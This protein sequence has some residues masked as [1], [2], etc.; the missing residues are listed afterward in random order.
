[1]TTLPANVSGLEPHALIS[2]P[3]CSDAIA[4]TYTADLEPCQAS[5]HARAQTRKPRFAMEH[6]YTSQPSTD[7]IR[8][9]GFVCLKH[10]HDGSMSCEAHPCESSDFSL[11]SAS[12]G[13]CSVTLRGIWIRQVPL[14]FRLCSAPL[15]PNLTRYQDYERMG[16]ITTGFLLYGIQT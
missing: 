4:W 14:E 1:M 8:L 16:D 9:F 10:F 6:W 2:S 5:S 11:G 12:E 7:I 15:L 3:C 13:G